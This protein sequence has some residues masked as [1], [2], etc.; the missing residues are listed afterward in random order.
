MRGFALGFIALILGACQSAL[1]ADTLIE[2]GSVFVGDNSAAQN[3]VIAI[4]DDRILYVGPQADNIQAEKIVDATGMIV[5]PGFIDPHT[6]S[7][8]DLESSDHSK[9]QNLNYQFQGVT[10]VINGNDGFGDPDIA[11]TSERLT[12]AGI[13]TNTA[14]FIGHGALRQSVMGGD[15]RAPT[16]VELTGMKD[17]IQAAMENG[18]L[19]LS[20]GLFYA[21]GSFSDTDEVVELA[22][23]AAQYGGVYDS[24]IRDEST[25]SVGL[26]TAIDEIIEIAEQADIPVHIAHIK[27]LGVD[28][29]GA[30][31]DIIAAVELARAKGLRVT[32]DQYPWRASGT[33]ISNALIP[34]W[35]KAGS[36]ADYMARLN[37][38]ELSEQIRSETAEN[39]R[40][41]GGPEAV[42]ITSGEPGWINKTL[43]QVSQDFGQD[44]I[45]M[46]IEIANKGDAR[47]ASFNMNPKDVENF[48]VQDWVMTSSDGST[49]HPRKFAS[50]PKKYRD[51]VIDKPLLSIESFLYRSSG[52]VAETFNLCERGFLKNGFFA[53]LV[54][55]DPEEYSPLADFQNAERLSTGVQYLFVNGTMTIDNGEALPA[56]PGKVVRKCQED[57]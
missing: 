51:Y 9:R 1:Q 22:K 50:Y 30:S 54:I 41:R 8:E 32:A 3:L 14:F 48:M 18:G 21:P 6:H 55:F 43:L 42:L 10:T 29:W 5:A 44:P 47:I 16:P 23:V 20:T 12:D 31:D 15:D 13:G 17:Q 40:K 46:A 27:A 19:G 39:L 34:R 11:G 57:T 35:V 49:G 53:D 4:K 38:P 26:L 7:I 37:N 25:Y 45:D 24:H 36:E 33:R 28:V 52:Q 56:L 2:N